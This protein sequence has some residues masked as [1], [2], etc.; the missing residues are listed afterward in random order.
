MLNTVFDSF[1]LFVSFFIKIKQPVSVHHPY[2][3]RE[4]GEERV[5]I[6]VRTNNE[7]GVR[8]LIYKMKALIMSNVLEDCCL[9]M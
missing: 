2:F 3:G 9:R 4:E 6:L 8:T 7:V 5:F 1:F